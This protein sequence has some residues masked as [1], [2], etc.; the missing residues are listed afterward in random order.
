MKKKRADNSIALRADVRAG[1]EEFSST[2]LRELV[3]LMNNQRLPEEHQIPANI[4]RLWQRL[5]GKRHID[6][7]TDGYHKGTSFAKQAKGIRVSSE[8]R[9]L[10]DTENHADEHAGDAGNMR[11]NLT[12]RV[13]WAVAPVNKASAKA[14]HLFGAGSKREI[15][16]VAATAEDFLQQ[17]RNV[18]EVAFVGV[19]N[20]G[21]CSCQTRGTPTH[22][23]VSSLING[24]CNQIVSPMEAMEGTTKEAL[25]IE[26]GAKRKSSNIRLIDFP[27][28]F[29]GSGTAGHRAQK[30]FRDYLASRS[31]GVLKAVMLITDG[32]KGRTYHLRQLARLLE[33]HEVP[34]Y[35]CITRTDQCVRGFLL[36]TVTLLLH[37]KQRYPMMRGVLCTSAVRSA[38]ITKLQNVLAEYARIPELGHVMH[39]D[40]KIGDI[41]PPLPQVAAAQASHKVVTASQ[42]SRKFL[43]LHE[44]GMTAPGAQLKATQLLPR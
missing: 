28:H 33:E 6:K 26:C 10:V 42:T 19:I 3:D 44:G 11:I 4:M 2:P 31:E 8:A 30:L 5:E 24:V 13:A 22:A 14:M 9:A 35:Y 1:L 37:E 23:G 40:F 36:R 29:E 25:Y 43:R 27:G 18:P 41:L 17:D 39:T 20:Q 21:M 34:Y 12:A 32:H 15:S 38:G 7:F 16:H